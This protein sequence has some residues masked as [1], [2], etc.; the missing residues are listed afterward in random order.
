MGTRSC[1]HMP[2]S[3]VQ[4]STLSFGANSSENANDPSC[5]ERNVAHM[6][7]NS[8]IPYC[9]KT[10][11]RVVIAVRLSTTGLSARPEHHYS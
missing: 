1:A 9:M 3:P 10:P 2:K 6:I 7:P 5:A 11:R 8:L 4:R